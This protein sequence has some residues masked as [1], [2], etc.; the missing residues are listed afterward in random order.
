MT[1][2]AAPSSAVQPGDFFW[3]KRDGAST[4]VAHVV[5]DFVPGDVG[6]GT[7]DLYVAR[8][9]RDGRVNPQFPVSGISTARY[10]DDLPEEVIRCTR[11]LT[12]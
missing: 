2:D 9:G 4:I 6:A 10:A 8:C 1:L 3:R 7:G 12:T 11:C 5:K